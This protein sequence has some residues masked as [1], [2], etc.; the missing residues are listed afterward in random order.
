M[1]QPKEEKGPVRRLVL[2]KIVQEPNEGYYT[3]LLSNQTRVYFKPEQVCS[4]VTEF[5]EKETGELEREGK[6]IARVEFADP[7]QITSRGKY[8]FL[9]WLV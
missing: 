8:R 6:R 4:K 5:P 2:G 3:F 1:E 7:T 9:G